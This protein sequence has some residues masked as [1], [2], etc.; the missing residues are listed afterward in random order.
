MAFNDKA[1]LTLKGIKSNCITSKINVSNVMSPIYKFQIPNQ[2][3]DH[4]AAGILIFAPVAVAYLI[5]SFLLAVELQIMCIPVTRQQVVLRKFYRQLQ[6]NT[7]S[8]IQNVQETIFSQF[9][10]FSHSLSANVF[11]FHKLFVRPYNL[12]EVIGYYRELSSQV[13][14]W[15]P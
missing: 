1:L 14:R 9:S 12:M 7:A 8:V 5:Y 11:F 6:L 13:P 3:S 10:Q 4:T 15:Q 2:I